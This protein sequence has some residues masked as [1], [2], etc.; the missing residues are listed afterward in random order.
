MLKYVKK[1]MLITI[2]VIGAFLMTGCWQEQNIEKR[3][4]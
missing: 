1:L 2:F 3:Y 4:Y